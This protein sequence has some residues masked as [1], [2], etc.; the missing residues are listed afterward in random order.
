MLAIAVASFAASNGKNVVQS[1]TSTAKQNLKRSYVAPNKKTLGEVS[2]PNMEEKK[3]QTPVETGPGFKIRSD[4]EIEADL[5]KKLNMPST[6]VSPA[7]EKIIEVTTNNAI[8]LF[9]IKA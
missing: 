5:I 8:E 6:S 1:S 4:Q 3:Q 9:K 2:P 7:E